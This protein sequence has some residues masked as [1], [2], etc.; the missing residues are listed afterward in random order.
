MFAFHSTM[1][2]GG[3]APIPLNYLVVAGGGGG[4]YSVGGVV[5]LAA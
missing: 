3:A 4:Y 5:E 1:L 2:A